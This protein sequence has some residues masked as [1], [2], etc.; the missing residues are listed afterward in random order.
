MIIELSNTGNMSTGQNQNQS[1]RGA[2]NHGYNNHY[3][4]NSDRG[5][6]GGESRNYREGF[7]FVD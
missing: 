2:G 4:R 3:Y 5:H 6:R 7:K 1:R